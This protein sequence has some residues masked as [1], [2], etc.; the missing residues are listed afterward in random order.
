MEL[1]LNVRKYL[2]IL[3]WKVAHYKY[4]R[5]TEL[6]S[7]HVIEKNFQNKIFEICIWAIKHILY[8]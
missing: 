3:K 7:K 4:W 1:Y 6:H 5:F 2:S 8:A